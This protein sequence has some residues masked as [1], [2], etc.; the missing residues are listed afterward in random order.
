[1]AL[2]VVGKEREGRGE[3]GREGG[4]ARE[5][6]SGWGGW[7]CGGGGGG[8]DDA[9]DVCVSPHTLMR[10]QLIKVTEHLGVRLLVSPPP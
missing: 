3:G 5:W 6:R 8:V 10:L 7:W 1:M 2:V 4:R 9:Y